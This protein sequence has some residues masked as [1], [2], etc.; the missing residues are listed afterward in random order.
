MIGFSKIKNHK[1]LLC[2]L[3]AQLEKKERT[4]YERTARFNYWAWHIIVGVS[5]LSSVVS[6]LTAA[7]IDSKGFEAYG[8]ILLVVV[9]IV[10]AG[11]TGLLHLY[12]FREKEALR[13]EGRIEVN[14]II[15]NAK[16]CLALAKNEEDFQKAFHSVRERF[17]KLEQ[18]QHRRDIA[19]RS[20]EIPKLKQ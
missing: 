12:K 14:D 6:A 19:M 20:D 2:E 13:E 9:P 7:L 5:L 16:S 17:F 10:G 15:E 11:A 4:F 3:I 1:E 8:K 18:S